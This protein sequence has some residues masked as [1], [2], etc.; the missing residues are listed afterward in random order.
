METKVELLGKTY[1]IQTVNTP[2][3]EFLCPQCLVAK[4]R[5]VVYEGAVGFDMEDWMECNECNWGQEAWMFPHTIKG[6]DLWTVG[7]HYSNDPLSELSLE[8]VLAMFVWPKKPTV[9]VH[10]C[11]PHFIGTLDE[12]IQELKNANLI[13]SK[14][15]AA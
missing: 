9:G 14:V 11:D 5:T 2:V 13:E 15:E 6:T 8:T 12:C 4:C 3:F 7:G 10:G 1:M